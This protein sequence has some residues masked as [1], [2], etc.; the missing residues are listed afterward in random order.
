MSASGSN[1]ATH[2]EKSGNCNRRRAVGGTI[3][4]VVTDVDVCHYTDSVDVVVFEDGVGLV[5]QMVSWIQILSFF[6]L[7]ILALLHSRK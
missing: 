5:A 4:C 7:K 1:C 2:L 3:E 6:L